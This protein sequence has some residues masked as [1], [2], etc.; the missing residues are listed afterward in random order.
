M[1]VINNKKLD[2]CFAKFFG[3]SIKKDEAVYSISLVDVF[4]NKE[5]ASYIFEYGKGEIL[6]WRNCFLGDTQSF[7]P[8]T[9]VKSVC[10]VLTWFY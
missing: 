9:C 2:K 4:E 10:W 3:N 1:S 8:E 6:E 5:I 7:N